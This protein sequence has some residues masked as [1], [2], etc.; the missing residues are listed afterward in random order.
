VPEAST[1]GRLA[2]IAASAR[3]EPAQASSAPG[4]QAPPAP[5]PGAVPPVAEPD[6]EGPVPDASFSAAVDTERKVLYKVK[7]PGCK[8]VIPVYTRE[9]PLKIKCDDCGKEGVLK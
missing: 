2:S 1:L 7:C 3:K 8:T 6:T 9:R 4:V 5:A